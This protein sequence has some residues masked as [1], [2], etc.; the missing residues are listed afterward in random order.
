MNF[1]ANALLAIGA[2]PV[3][4]LY[5]KEI[6]EL[7]RW[8]DA[9]YINIGCLDDSQQ[10]AMRL[11]AD[12]AFE[13]RIPWVL[14]PVAVA[15]SRQRAEL[16]LELIEKYRPSIIRGNASEIRALSALISG[17]FPYDEVRCGVDSTHDSSAVLEDAKELSKHS[18]A[19]VAMSGPTDFVVTPDSVD[20]VSGGAAI[21]S[22]VTAMGCVASAL[23]TAFAATETSGR[24]AAFK[25]LALMKK[26]GAAAAG[27]SRG[28]GSFQVAFLDELSNEYR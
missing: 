3:M 17:T 11:A 28:T 12:E 9:L 21:M 25:A 23:C 1:V 19:T 24:E 22:E 15:A 6:R 10:T 14:D 20:T 16:S 5:D 4:S 8:A 7:T 13:R 2:S 27:V 18:G 26:A